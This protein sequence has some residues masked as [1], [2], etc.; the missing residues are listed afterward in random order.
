MELFELLVFGIIGAISGLV[1]ASVTSTCKKVLTERKFY[2]T[3][4]PYIVPILTWL[5]IIKS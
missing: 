1:L 3:V 2:Y 4:T 5:H